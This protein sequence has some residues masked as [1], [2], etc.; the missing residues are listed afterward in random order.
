MRLGERHKVSGYFSLRIPLRFLDPLVLLGYISVM[1]N[2]FTAVYVVIVL[3]F[4]LI[5]NSR[6]GAGRVVLGVEDPNGWAQLISL[7]NFPGTFEV[8]GKELDTMFPLYSILAIR[9]PTAIPWVG[10]HSH[11][12]IDSPSDILFL[13]PSDPILANVG[14]TT[15]VLTPHMANASAKEWKSV[16]DAHFKKKQF[17]AA[18]VAYSNGLDEDPSS[19]T[20]RLNRCLAHIRLTNFVFAAH[21]A[22]M[23][24]SQADLDPADRTKA[25]YRA[26]LA[27]YGSGKYRE[28]QQHYNECLIIDPDLREAINGVNEC[29][30][31]IQE[32]EHGIYDWE[33]LFMQGE[34]PHATPNVADYTGP[35]KVSSMPH[36]GGGRGLITTKDIAAGELLVCT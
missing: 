25:L 2:H 12:R 33:K 13:K 3:F 30:I 11:V 28:A 17:F 24:L 34:V 15:G 36:R 20:I 35:V 31:R 10:E 16:G 1:P 6:V 8:S 21:D 5:D 32:Q 29:R 4:L 9:E 23:V 27:Q 14:W 18:A 19:T 7:Y 26:A 22:Q